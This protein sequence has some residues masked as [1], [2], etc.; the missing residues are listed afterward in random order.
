MTACVAHDHQ[1]LNEISND[2]PLWISTASAG[3]RRPTHYFGLLD[4]RHPVS[5]S[6]ADSLRT[7]GLGYLRHLKVA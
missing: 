3:Q 4:T 1:L 7:A 2:P 6:I 5:C